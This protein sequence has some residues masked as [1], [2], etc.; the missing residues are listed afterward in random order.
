[1]AENSAIEWTDHT[2]NPWIGCQKV[3]PGCDHCYAERDMALRWKRVEWG[4][5]AERQRTSEVNW[6]LPL[7]WDREAAAAGERHRVF[8]ASLADVFDNAVPVEWRDDLFE[9]IRQTPNLDWMLLTKR[10]QN[11]E[12][13]LPGD[14]G[15]G[16][17]NVWLGVSAENQEEW[18]RRISFL[19]DTPAVC[20]FVS[21]EPLLGPIDITSTM[22]RLAYLDHSLASVL[23]ILPGIDLVIVGGE[24]GPDRRPMDLEWARSIRDQC[25]EAGVAFFG[26]QWDK[27]QPLPDDLMIRQM[28][29]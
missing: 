11:F 21:A 8:C 13:M 6:K 2:F 20:L 10:P 18:D 19:I 28:P 25:A 12:T 27:V 22:T 23:D 7:K 24:S 16:Y 9:L 5:G 15:D 26:K 4:P 3:S 1:M 17:P 14:W 29:Q